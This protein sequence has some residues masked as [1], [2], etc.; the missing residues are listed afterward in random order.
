MRGSRMRTPSSLVSL[1][2][3][4]VGRE[5]KKKNNNNK[6][7][8]RRTSSQELLDMRLDLR[9]MFAFNRAKGCNQGIGNA[10]SKCTRLTRSAATSHKRKNIVYAQDTSET[11]RPCHDLAMR[12][13]QEVLTKRRI[14]NED[15]SGRDLTIARWLCTDKPDTSAANFPTA[16][17]VRTTEIVDHSVH[18][19]AGEC[20]TGAGGVVMRIK[21]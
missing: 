4:I 11:E 9:R 14:I 17:S 13:A 21:S 6:K 1:K 8:G 5:E 18:R 3:H 19:H 10:M 20:F 12:C 16:T 2:D 7:E 15:F